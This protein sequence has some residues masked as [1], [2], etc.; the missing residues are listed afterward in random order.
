MAA[1]VDTYFKLTR[2]WATSTCW[3]A[4]TCSIRELHGLG[5]FGAFCVPFF[6]KHFTVTVASR[7]LLVLRKV[8]TAKCNYNNAVDFVFDD[9]NN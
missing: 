6:L 1:C 7:H 2:V 8:L 4:D 5:R 9:E 3:P